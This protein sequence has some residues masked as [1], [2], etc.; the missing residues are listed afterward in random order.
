M[1]LIIIYEALMYLLVLLFNCAAAQVSDPSVLN[2]STPNIVWPGSDVI[3]PCRLQPP[4]SAE[5]MRVEWTRPDLEPEFIHVYQ[6]GRFLYELQNPHYTYRTS[7]FVDQL[8][9]GDVSLKLS[10]VTQSDAGT[11]RC[12]LPSVQQE[13]SVQ[14]SVVSEVIGSD[15]AVQAVVGD[16]VILPCH[17]EPPVDVTTL[18]VEWTTRNG[19]VVH[20][21]ESRKDNTDIQND[22]F[23]GRTSLFHD[24]M[25]KGNI[26]LKLIN[27]TLT[28]AGNYTCFVRKLIQQKKDN[29]G[30]FVDSKDKKG[31]DDDSKA[32]STVP[33]GPT[34]PPALTA[35]HITLIVAAVVILIAGV[36]AGL[37]WWTRQRNR[38]QNQAEA[39]ENIPMM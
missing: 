19:A 31:R 9:N 18:T 10:R 29:V 39:P 5:S 24:E 11:Y 21:F 8:P 38:R 12:S 17:M 34:N 1:G 36:V 20:K 7:L 26:S 13:A 14:L 27:V 6:D 28:D 23:K 33:T 37:V 2:C 3:L 30:L 35:C 25:H 16:D 32:S 4:L 15:Q 22:T